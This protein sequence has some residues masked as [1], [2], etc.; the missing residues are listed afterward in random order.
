MYV[1]EYIEVFLHAFC[2]VTIR[3]FLD[4]IQ[5]IPYLTLKIQGQGDDQ[6]LSKS[7]Q[8]IYIS[9]PSILPKN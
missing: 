2:F 8:V 9:G 5:R 3:P 7:N 4:E 1:M 6:N